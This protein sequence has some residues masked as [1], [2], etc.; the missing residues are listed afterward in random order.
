VCDILGFSNLVENHSLDVVVERA[1]GW[2]RRSLHHSVFQNAFPGHIPEKGEFEEH[3]HVGV[4]WFSDTVL[5]YTLRDDDEA[6]R[7]LIMS[8]GWLLFETVIAGTT[9]IR[10]GIS[11][12]EA[13]IDRKNAVFV[14]KPIIEAYRLEQSQQWSGGAL[15]PAARDRVPQYARGGQ[16]A[17]WWV[18]PY[19]VPL[20]GAH[21]CDTLAINWTWGE[22]SVPLVLRWSERSDF[23]TDAE[24]REKPDICQKFVNTKEFHDRVCIQCQ[25]HRYP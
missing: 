14:G 15:T 25:P 5:L 7:R 3:S 24:Q 12:G 18:V 8:V 22:H 1:L 19:K 11:Y 6:V 20:K 10:A 13:Y 17:D 4:A 16:F 9:R 23:P 2:F 21:L